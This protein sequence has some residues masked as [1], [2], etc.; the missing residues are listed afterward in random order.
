VGRSI[1]LTKIKSISRKERVVIKEVVEDIHR[2]LRVPL[3]N[4]LPRLIG[5]DDHI[6]FIGWWLTDGSHHIVDILTIAGVGGVGK[7][8]LA[9]Y[10]FGL[11]SSKFDKSS[12]VQGI[13][14]RC[15]ERVNGLLKLQK[16]LH[17]DISKNMELR[18][19]DC[20]E[21]TSKIEN[22]LARK[23]VF[24]VLDDIGS[25]EQLDAL[26]GNKGLHP[27]TKVI[28][29]TKDA[30]LTKRCALFKSHDHPNHK[31]VLLNGLRKSTSLKL[32]CI[33]A[34]HS[35]NPKEG[36]EEVSKE[37]VKYC[38]GHPLAI[39]VLGKSLYQRDVSHWEN[40]IKMLKKEP[41][42]H[43]NTALK[44][45]FDALLYTND[46]ELFKHIA[47]FFV[48]IDRDVAQTILDAC[49]I[50]TEIGMRN[51]VDKSLLSIESNNELAMH[52]LIQEMGRNLVR[53]ESPV[54]PWKRSRLWCPKESFEALNQNKGKRSLLGLALDMIMLDKKK[55]RGSFEL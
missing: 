4:V 33:H 24:I 46:K 28:V 32:L 25:L 15:N 8:Y 47:C 49:D 39:E 44:M 29:T 53:Q 34:F 1:L 54:K 14:A 7:T 21:Y 41:H 23:R 19:N 45:S 20:I 10:V 3:C 11:H 55:S 13:D 22:V 37:L 12:F 48:G 38:D 6:N 40:Y 9:K 50:N 17:G 35:Q 51:L 31:E 52:S 2:R 36:Y 43:I 42:A 27:G 30:S 18:V 5:M 26:L 16:Q